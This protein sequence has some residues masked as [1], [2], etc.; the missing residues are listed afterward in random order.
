MPEISEIEPNVDLIE[1]DG[2]SFYIV[3]TAHVSEHSADLVEK[4]IQLG[5]TALD[6]AY[7]VNSHFA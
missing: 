2:R 4:T 7:R 3:G 6:I 1:A 5:V